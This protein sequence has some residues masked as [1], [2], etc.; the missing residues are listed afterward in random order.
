MKKRQ[1]AKTTKS[2]LQQAIKLILNFKVCAILFQ[3]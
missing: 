3:Q 2:P 1:N